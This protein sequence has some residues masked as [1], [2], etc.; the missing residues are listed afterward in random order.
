MWSAAGKSDNPKHGKQY[1]FQWTGCT[2]VGP[3]P[4]IGS[5][6]AANEPECADPI[7]N[8][9]DDYIPLFLVECPQSTQEPYYPDLRKT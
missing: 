8:E 3:M 1:I 7:G 6:S 5:G 9:G 4:Y 2:Q